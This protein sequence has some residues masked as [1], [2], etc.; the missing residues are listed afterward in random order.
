MTKV[1]WLEM[2]WFTARVLILFH[3]SLC[4]F[5]WKYHTILIT[6]ILNKLWNQQVWYL[7]LCSF[8]RSFGLVSIPW[9]YLWILGWLFPFLQKNRHQ[10]FDMN[11]T[12]SVHH[13]GKYCH[14]S[15]ISLSIHAHGIVS[16]LLWFSLISLRS[17]CSFQC[18]RL[19]PPW[20]NLVICVLF[21]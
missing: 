6:I 11:C 12:E 7:Q 2:W 21:F 4:L 18:I 19:A 9:N 8:S 10:D 13:S 20:L 1:N 15:T 14:L 3:C 16:H 17:V 5:L